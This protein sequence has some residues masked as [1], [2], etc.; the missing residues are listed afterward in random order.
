LKLRASAIATNLFNCRRSTT[1]SSRL[2]LRP[3][4]SLSGLTPPVDAALA[5][6]REAVRKRIGLSSFELAAAILVRPLPC[7]GAYGGRPVLI[8]DSMEFVGLMFHRDGSEASP[9][10]QA[11]DADYV[12]RLAQAYDVSAFDRVLVGQNSFWPD[13]MPIASH[14]AAVTSRL[15]FMVAHRPGFLAPTM[16]A[17]A[18]ATLDQLSGGRAA[19]HVISAANDIETQCDGDFLTKE[20][21][22]RRSREFVEI[23]KS[24][25]TRQEPTSFDGEFY[26]FNRALSEVRPVQTPHPPIYWAG[27]SEP[28]IRF[29]GEC[30]DVYALGGGALAS[31]RDLV[32]LVKASAEKA[33]R[34]LKFQASLRVIVAPGENEAWARA[35]VILERL[36]EAV[37]QR[38]QLVGDLATNKNS[39]GHAAART[40]IGDR[41]LV[42]RRLWTAPARATNFWVPP[43]LVGSYDQVA[44]ALGD[45]RAAGIDDFLIRGFDPLPDIVEFS[46]HLIPR[47]RAQ[48]T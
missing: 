28:A 41:E 24:I 22:Y 35:D 38:Q 17:R 46:E 19:I 32:G 1:P 18:F 40:A 4:R 11:F 21:R 12:R 42:D 16:A 6:D 23:L 15:K 10:S 20:D 47:V 3:D 2:S 8:G 39:A 31:V 29:A 9:P 37:A 14:I 5:N 45:Y 36:T 27:T 33:G 30:A 26:R 43:V 44:E 34:T 7:T 25:W 48:A 13:S